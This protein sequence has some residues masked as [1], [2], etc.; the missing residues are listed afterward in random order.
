VHINECHFLDRR[1]NFA[2][3]MDSR[4][5]QLHCTL[6]FKLQPYVYGVSIL[7]CLFVICFIISSVA[8][9]LGYPK[10]RFIEGDELNTMRKDVGIA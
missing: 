8:H 7:F 5:R 6:G 3:I 9:S 2:E 1:V 4:E 10:G